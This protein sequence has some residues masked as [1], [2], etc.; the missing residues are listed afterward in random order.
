MLGTGLR[1]KSRLRCGV[2]VGARHAASDRFAGWLRVRRR[3]HATPRLRDSRQGIPSGAPYDRTRWQRGFGQAGVQVELGPFLRPP[4][5]RRRPSQRHG[6]D[7]SCPPRSPPSLGS[8]PRR[9]PVGSAGQADGGSHPRRAPPVPRV[10]SQTLPRSDGAR[11]RRLIRGVRASRRALGRRSADDAPGQR[12]GSC[13][14]LV[15][16]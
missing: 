1:D 9:S 4:S 15:A 8:A 16:T 3:E 14:A 11:V 2:K 13:W 12:W 10:R 5:P 6:T 7:F